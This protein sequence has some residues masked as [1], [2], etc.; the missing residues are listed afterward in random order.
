MAS[1][2]QRVLS[3]ENRL[4]ALM[5][6]TSRDKMYLDADIAGLRQQVSG[7]TPYKSTKTAYIGDTSVYFEMCPLGNITV[8]K[9]GDYSLE[10]I[11]DKIRLTFEPLE[12]VTDITI[13][14]L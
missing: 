14:I 2:E 4:S 5:S 13:S 10:R 8:Y 9:D 3:L 12:E 7:L 6:K 1:I 11:G